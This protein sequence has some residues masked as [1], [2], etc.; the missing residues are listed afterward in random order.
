[1]NQAEDRSSR[2]GFLKS[3]TAAAC[4]VAGSKIIHAATPAPALT[5]R[6]TKNLDPNDAMAKA[7]GYVA[8]RTKAD[9]SKFPQLKT[10]EGKAQACSNCMLYNNPKGGWGQC[11]IFR[12]GLVPD[13]GWCM[14]WAKKV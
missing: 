1:M 4:L 8:D 2:R 7:L 11:T 10:P 14:S 12:Q 9:A 5:S 13:N 6:P 3:L